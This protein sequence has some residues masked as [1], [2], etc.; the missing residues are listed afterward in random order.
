M[1]VTVIFGVFF[2]VLD[3]KSD[4]SCSF[5][6]SEG[7]LNICEPSKAR[8]RTRKDYVISREITTLLKIAVE[9]IILKFCYSF[10]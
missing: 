5:D 3:K 4:L 9:N 8:A 1:D 7:K 2:V 10:D 6:R